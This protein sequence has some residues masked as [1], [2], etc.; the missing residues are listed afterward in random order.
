MRTN[1]RERRRTLV[2]KGDMSSEIASFQVCMYSCCALGFANYMPD[3]ID[4]HPS[5][6][7]ES[8]LHANVK[9]H[10][11]FDDIIDFEMNDFKR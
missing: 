1:A 4:A 3:P 2:K 10:I 6:S 7:R 5:P 8:H 9:T 11:S